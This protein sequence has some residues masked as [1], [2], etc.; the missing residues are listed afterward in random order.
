M[1]GLNLHALVRGGINAVN[2]DETVQLF[3]SSGYTKDATFAQDP[4]Y[5][6]PVNV[7]CQ[8]QPLSTSDLRAIEG[9][10]LQD[11]LKAFYFV[12]QVEGVVRPRVKGGDKIIRGNGEV[13]LVTAQPEGWDTVGWSHVICTLQNGS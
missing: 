6:D 10:N 12:G 3:V 9:L 1:N 4:T 11:N 7:L 2:P 5:A 13:W 8:V